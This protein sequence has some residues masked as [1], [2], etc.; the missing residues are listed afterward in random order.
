MAAAQTQE[1]IQPRVL[2]K[3]ITFALLMA[4]VPIGSYFASI[5]WL[6]DGNTTHAALTAVA[7][8][9]IVLAGYVYLAFAEDAAERSEI[10]EKKAQ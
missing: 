8:A 10:K 1:G 4:V 5:K 7:A 3:L 6:Y 2:G 9:N